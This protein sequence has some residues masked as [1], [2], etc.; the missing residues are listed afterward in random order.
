MKPS[1]AEAPGNWNL[2]P[3]RGGRE[4]LTLVTVEDVGRLWPGCESEGTWGGQPGGPGSQGATTEAVE[5]AGFSLTPG[6]R[7]LCGQAGIA[8]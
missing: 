8:T 1:L 7:P 4:A 6:N 2:L 3:G 5:G